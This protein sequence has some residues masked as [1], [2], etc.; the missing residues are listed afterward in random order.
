MSLY[1]KGLMVKRE[2]KT[3]DSHAISF[4]IQLLYLA[5]VNSKVINLGHLKRRI[6][7]GDLPDVNVGINI[8]LN[9]QLPCLSVDGAKI[10]S[11]F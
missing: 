11:L 1:L 3:E 7:A 4:D 6:L 5:R 8:S 2:I 9:H 10:T